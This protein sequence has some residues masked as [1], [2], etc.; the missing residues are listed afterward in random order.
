MKRAFE[1]LKHRRSQTAVSILVFATAFVPGCS[2]KKEQ[3]PASASNKVVIKGSNTVGEELAP[4]LTA[5]Y[6]KEHPE[7]T[8]DLESKGTGTGF[9]GLMA[10][11]CDM[12]AASRTAIKAEEEQLAARNMQLNDYLIGSYAIAVLVH[13]DNPVSNLTT[14]QVRDIFT[15]VVRN[16]KDVGG[17]DA[18]IHLFIR[19]PVSGTYLGFKELGMQNEPYTTN[20]ITALTNYA[21]IVK[22]VA[23]DRDGIGY[24]SIQLA[25]TPGVKG[26]SIGSITP[27]TASVNDGVYPF[28][29]RLHFYTDKAS[30]KKEARDFIDFVLSAR[31]QQVAAEMGTVPHP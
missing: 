3:A 26:L 18:T 12:A 30:E 23:A 29:R 20:N 7:I 5:E 31:G 11:K 4:R 19:D 24:A 22:G 27:T 25:S 10:G 17:A 14:S 8:F 6:K 16:W 13:A 28:A 21:E 15:G 9:A 2:E 1:F